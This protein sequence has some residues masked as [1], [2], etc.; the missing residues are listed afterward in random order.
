MERR[1]SVLQAYAAARQG[2][3]L[4]FYAG[5]DACSVQDGEEKDDEECSMHTRNVLLPR[6]DVDVEED[7]DE[8]DENEEAR[9]AHSGDGGEAAE[10]GS[11]TDPKSGESGESSESAAS[12]SERSSSASSDS[13][14]KSE[15]PEAFD[16]WNRP[17]YIPLNETERV[18]VRE[19]R[20]RRSLAEA[21]SQAGQIARRGCAKPP[22][23]AVLLL[24]EEPPIPSRTRRRRKGDGSDEDDEED[25]D[26]D[27]DEEEEDKEEEPPLR[28]RTSSVRFTEAVVVGSVPSHKKGLFSNAGAKA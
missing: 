9:E 3:S 7:E 23:P 13:S 19:A 15:E 6:G 20:K 1:R 24:S 25:D 18:V 2:S 16:K 10:E 5:E 26:D 8:D 14:D 17:I 22:Q 27:E 21:D 12:A 28:R 11:D 4:S